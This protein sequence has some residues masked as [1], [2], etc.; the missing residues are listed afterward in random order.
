MEELDWDEH[1]A[2]EECAIVEIVKIEERIAQ[3]LIDVQVLRWKEVGDENTTIFSALQ[4]CCCVCFNEGA[5]SSEGQDAHR[6]ISKA[7]GTSTRR[8]HSIERAVVIDGRTLRVLKNG[9]TALHD[10]TYCWKA[11]VR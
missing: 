7:G 10:L 1:A 11:C 8:L 9:N 4:G 6:K 2:R 5:G 3:E